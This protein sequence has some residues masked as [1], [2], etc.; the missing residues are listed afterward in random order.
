MIRDGDRGAR[1]RCR[2][3]VQLPGGLRLKRRSMKDEVKR[4]GVGAGEGGMRAI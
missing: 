1:G 3:G 4:G 2:E